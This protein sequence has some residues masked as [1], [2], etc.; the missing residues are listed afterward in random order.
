MASSERLKKPTHVARTR[1]SE[2][3]DCSCWIACTGRSGA[4]GVNLK[5]LRP[6]TVGDIADRDGFS[7]I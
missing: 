7:Q 1:V 2:D 4:V 3:L 5:D 6:G